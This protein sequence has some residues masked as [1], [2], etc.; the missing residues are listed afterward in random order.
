MKWNEGLVEF[1]FLLRGKGEGAGEGLNRMSGGTQFLDRIRLEVR[2][3]RRALEGFQPGGEEIHSEDKSGRDR[4]PRAR[5]FDQGEGFAADL[6]KRRGLGCVELEDAT[7]QF[8]N[9]L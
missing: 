8:S 6:L 2:P 1:R 3:V 9:N 5:H 7:H 4:H